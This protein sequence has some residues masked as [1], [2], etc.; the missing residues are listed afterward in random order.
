V[1]ALLYFLFS[2]DG[3]VT[4]FVAE[5]LWVG[6]RPRSAAARRVLIASALA[7]GIA[8]TY[9]VAQGVNALWTSGLTRFDARASAPD[10][11]TA[12]VLLSGSEAIILGWDGPRP[13][14]YQS[15]VERVVEAARVYTLL[16]PAS[17]WIISSG[18][19]PSA[20]SSLPSSGVVM[21]DALVT[22]GVPA[23]Q[24]LVEATSVNTHT[25]AVAIADMLQTLRPARVVLVT[26]A[27]HMPRSLG[28]F[29]AVGV[30]ALPAIAPD[31]GLAMSWPERLRPSAHAL[32]FSG[33]LIHE[34]IGTTY[35]RLR[36]WWNAPSPA[37]I[38]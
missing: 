11:R 17:T 5:A 22:L 31:S 27:Y 30:D 6:V 14:M 38:R 7:Y 36:G 12:I 29:R 3:V 16:P 10:D 35:Y 8:S 13:H 19:G 34:F 37:R 21:R 26:S 2:T 23:S 15:E 9:A 18:G 32:V 24:I 1:S 25:Q 28:V 4:V 20:P 33:L